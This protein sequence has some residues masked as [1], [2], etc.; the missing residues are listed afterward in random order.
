LASAPEEHQDQQSFVGSRW[1]KACASQATGS[2]RRAGRQY[3][4]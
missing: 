2:L 3:R 1:R 4:P